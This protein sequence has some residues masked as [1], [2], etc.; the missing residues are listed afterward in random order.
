MKKRVLLGLAAIA[1]VAFL[2]SCGKYPQ[3]EVDATNA[4]IAAAQ[5]AEANVYVPSEFAQLQDSMN[6]VLAN[7]EAQK[8]KLFKKFG[9]VKEEL[10]KTLTLANKVAADAGTKKEEV[11]KEAETLLNNIKTVIDENG[12]LIPKLPKGKEGAAVIE[13]MK[14]DLATLDTS[15][16][17]AQGLYEKGS[18]M[19]A[20]NKVKAANE[21]AVSLNTEIKEVLTKARIKF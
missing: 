21:K 19:D 6:V 2:T 1:M 18:Y 15:V 14:A 11:R 9:P 10:T 13:Q 8:S 5:A 16:A 7:A 3:A 12:K 4:A 20:L 17:D